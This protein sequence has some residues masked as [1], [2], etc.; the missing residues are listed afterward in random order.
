M[1]LLS[2]DFINSLGS[3]T[4]AVATPA[5]V[6]P[7]P[8]QQP[9]P[10]DTTPAPVDNSQDIPEPQLPQSLNQTLLQ[11]Q[12]AEKQKEQDW[13]STPILG[14]LDKITGA[15]GSLIENF[16]KATASDA[17]SVGL[18]AIKPFYNLFTGKSTSAEDLANEPVAKVPW[19]G[20]VPTLY[21]D[22]KSAQDAGL[23]PLASPLFAG[24]NTALKEASLLPVSEFLSNSFAPRAALSEG[25]QIENTKP[26]Q[27]AMDADGS[28]S[29]K[30]PSTSEHYT[31]TKTDASQFGGNTNNI[32]WQITPSGEGANALSVVKVLGKNTE[33]GSFVKTDFGMKQVEQGDFGPQIKLFSQDVKSGSPGIV[34]SALAPSMASDIKPPSSTVTPPEAAGSLPALNAAESTPNVLPS[35][36]TP[37]FIPPAP[38]KGMANM[39]VTADQLGTLGQISRI[40]GIDPSVRDAVIKTITGKSA[41]G[42]LTQAEYVKAAQTLSGFGDKYQDP[43][44]P[45]KLGPVGYAK[46]IL[47]PQRHYFDYVEDTYG[48]P[49]KSQVYTPMEEGARLSKNLESNLNQKALDE[50]WGPLSSAS[51][52]ENRRLVDAYSRGNT[53]A[54]TNNPDLT[55]ELK[56]QLIDTAGKL[57]AYYDETGPLLNVPKEIFKENYVPAIQDLGGVYNRYKDLSTSATQD[58]FAKFKRK[59]NLGTMI[60]DPMVTMQIYNRQGARALHMGPTLE[61]AKNLLK[62]I[63]P[64]FA[65]SANSYIQEKMGFSGGMEK[66][67]D[68]FVPAMNKNLSKIGVTLPAD[69]SRQAINFT[70]SGMYSSLLSGP[71]SS[72]KQAFQL[73]TFVYARMGSKFMGP[74]MIKAYTAAGSDEVAKAG[75]HLN[76]S[77]PYGEEL[78]KDANPVGKLANAYKSATQQVISPVTYVDNKM[79]DI[80]YH[81]GKMQWGDALARYNA[82]TITWPQL[83]NNLDFKAYSVADRNTIRQQLIGGNQDGAFITW[84]RSA[85]DDAMPPYRT[86]TGPRIGYGMSGKLGT[87]L[88]NYAIQSANVLSKWATTGQWDKLIRFAGG[89]KLTNDTL[90]KT[91]GLDFSKNLSQFQQFGNLYSPAVQLALNTA[92]YVTALTQNNKKEMNSN[93]DE[94]ARTIKTVGTPAGVLTG[95][96]MRFWKS[97]SAG[98]DQNGQY[99]IYDSYGKM[100]TSGDFNDLF[101]GTLM[102]FPVNDKTQEASLYNNMQNALTDQ[103][104]TQ[105]QVDQLL[106]EGNY[107]KMEALVKKTGVTPSKGAMKSSYVPRTQRLFQSLPGPLKAKFAGQVF[108]QQ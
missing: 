17:L 94:I 79:R 107:D 99:P 3:S 19:I 50:V 54:I 98:Q 29:A 8:I 86:A 73:P 104:A 95:N 91:F 46:S 103:A 12:G 31:M 58:F 56:Q 20:D 10:V 76:M 88:L 59:G 30:T 47:A 48:I 85:M 24:A 15:I 9:Q 66:F 37:P 81:Q 65:K 52:V 40:K 45:T 84:L 49:L 6:Q 23:G 57:R 68:S 108:N 70:L 75:F 72:F 97:Y 21:Q 77:T 67:I 102:G 87:G 61:N 33:V 16:P 96:A 64:E 27:Y 1:G 100:T 38:L 18:T 14:K 80:V 25:A 82:G 36:S 28:Y 92:N 41:V 13:A 83:E 35:K 71:L 44:V 78:T 7:A 11:E 2:D 5:P 93:A 34:S 62:T 89:A 42:E 39:P 53:A 63:P 60:D 43:S 4:P 74:A 106:R 22:E 105:Q 55:P 26:I 32:R 101:W 90:S 51:N 69:F